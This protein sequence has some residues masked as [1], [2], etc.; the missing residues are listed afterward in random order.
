MTDFEKY[1]WAA[2]VGHGLLLVW[3]NDRM[4]DGWQVA[5]YSDEGLVGVFTQLVIMFIVLQIVIAIG[6]SAI[7]RGAYKHGSHIH[8]ERDRYIEQKATRNANWMVVVAVVLIIGALI[9]DS[10]YTA[11]FPISL[12]PVT[13]S[14]MFYVL[15]STLMISALVEHLSAIAYHHIGTR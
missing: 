13:K 14:V 6:L 15:M 1:S 2:L 12:E 7:S 3:F 5:Q 9:F 8:D 4:L 10:S 11:W